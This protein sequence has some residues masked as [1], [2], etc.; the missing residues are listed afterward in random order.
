MQMKKPDQQTWGII[1]LGWLGKQLAQ[2]LQNKGVLCWGT[3]TKDFN[4]EFDPFPEQFCDVL[5]LNTPPLVNLT[6]SHFVE[7]IPSAF[8]GRIIF[9]S[10]TSVYGDLY[11]EITEDSIPLPNSVSARWLFEVENLLANKFS[12][13]V[14]II[15]SAGLIGSDRHPVFRLSQNKKEIEGSA[16]INLID[17]AD[18]VRIIFLVSQLEFLPLKLNAVAPYHPTK[19]EYYG[20]LAEKLGL[21]PLLFSSDHAAAKIIHSIILSNFY[22]EWINLRLERLD[23]HA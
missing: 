1:G 16:L 21:A 7:K 2:F 4:F 19:Q 10:S 6:P 17:S 13:R 5:V 8:N 14:V 12:S 11:G 18:L 20:F 15:R 9:I 3:T 23:K 22:S